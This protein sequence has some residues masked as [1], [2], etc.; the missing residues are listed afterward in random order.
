[1]QKILIPIDGSENSNRV[2]QFII[3]QAANCKDLVE[4]H[5]L[6]VQHRFP[7]TVKE[8]AQTKQYHH[9]EGIK[10]LAGARKLLDDAHIKY[11]YHIG[12]GDVGETVAQFVKELKCD[13]LAMGTRG[14][15]SVANMV[16]GS[17]ATKVLHLVNVPVLLVK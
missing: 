12:V 8:S 1:M 13:Q 14:M 15:S 3:K 11:A 2:V 7:G 17:A 6:N 16:M 5:L 10:A 4:I 9:D